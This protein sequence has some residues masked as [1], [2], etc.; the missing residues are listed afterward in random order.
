MAS[1][2]NEK[3]NDFL[4]EHKASPIIT[5]FKMDLIQVHAMRGYWLTEN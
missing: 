3:N 4:P 5:T 2:I 1:R